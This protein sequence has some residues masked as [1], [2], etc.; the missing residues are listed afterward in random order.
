MRGFTVVELVVT[1]AIIGI[2]AAAA[3]A[4]FVGKSSFESR[5]YY[6]AAIGVVRH[7]QKTAIAQRR[8]VLVV[9]TANQRIAACYAATCG[10]GERVAAPLNI[11]RASSTGAA[12]CLNDSDWLCAG[13]PEGVATI[14]S[15]ASPITFDALGRSGTEV[16]ITI[17]GSEAGDLTRRFK[18]ETETG[19]VHPA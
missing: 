15:T 12:N 11:H 19:Y 18:I 7:A 14:S 16:T 1:I 5:G 13:R 8:D 10:V 9:I 17:T 6:D 3:A 4:R 2:L